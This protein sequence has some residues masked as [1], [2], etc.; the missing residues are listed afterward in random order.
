M[1]PID[2]SLQK[3]L[4]QLIRSFRDC[5]MKQEQTIS[6]LEE[7]MVIDRKGRGFH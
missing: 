5:L 1:E 7:V 2:D 3:K 6:L 4:A